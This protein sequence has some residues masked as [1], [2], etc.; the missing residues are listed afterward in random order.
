MNMSTKHGSLNLDKA[1]NINET[2]Y[3]SLIGVGNYV[4]W[5]VTAATDN[6]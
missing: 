3:P 2:G 5:T 1:Q 4:P 6:L